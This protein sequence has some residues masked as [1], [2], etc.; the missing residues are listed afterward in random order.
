MIFL[1]FDRLNLKRPGA[2]Q[3]YQQPVYATA[4]GLT[5]AER[6]IAGALA[7]SFLARRRPIRASLDP[8]GVEDCISAEGEAI[9]VIDVPAAFASSRAPLSSSSAIS[10]GTF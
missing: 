10:I 7:T 6:R 5:E 3:S 4:F 2:R 9:R 1:G 8:R